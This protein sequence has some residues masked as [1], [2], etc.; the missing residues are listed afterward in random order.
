MTLRPGT[1][2]PKNLFHIATYLIMIFVLVI[3][4]KM[5][6]TFGII[7][8]LTRPHEI[9]YSFEQGKITI[10]LYFDSFEDFKFHAQL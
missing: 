2:V 8:F 7:T 3:N 10:S 1:D 9:V 6:T 5:P 4:S